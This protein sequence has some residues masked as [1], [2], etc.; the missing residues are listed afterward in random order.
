[1]MTRNMDQKL[2]V[3]SGTHFLSPAEFTPTAAMENNTYFSAKKL[4]VNT[5]KEQK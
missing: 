3:Q 4:G 2:A 5:L 1:M